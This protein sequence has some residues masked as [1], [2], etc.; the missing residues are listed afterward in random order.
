MRLQKFWT[1]I[2]IRWRWANYKI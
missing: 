2:H 1:E